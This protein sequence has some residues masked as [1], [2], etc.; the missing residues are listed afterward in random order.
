M[1]PLAD[2]ESSV[3]PSAAKGTIRRTRREDAQDLRVGGAKE[4][5][6]RGGMFAQ[7]RTIDL[8]AHT[9]HH[10]HELLR[11]LDGVNCAASARLSS[12]RRR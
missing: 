5:D 1:W 11:H 2:V 12:K 3:R 9:E 4:G 6:Q 8:H 10:L 7:Q